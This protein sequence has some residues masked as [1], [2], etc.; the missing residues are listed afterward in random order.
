MSHLS[1]IRKK[2]KKKQNTWSQVFYFSN[3][4][5]IAYEKKKFRISFIVCLLIVMLSLPVIAA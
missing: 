1:K 3:T 2:I 4:T 5:L